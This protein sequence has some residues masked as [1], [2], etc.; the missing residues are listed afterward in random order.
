LE[1]NEP[2]EAQSPEEVAKFTIGV[3]EA[4]SHGSFLTPSIKSFKKRQSLKPK[5]DY[6]GITPEMHL[7][8]ISRPQSQWAIVGGDGKYRFEVVGASRYQE[9]LEQIVGGRTEEGAEHYCGAILIPE[10]ENQYDPNAVVIKISGSTVAYLRRAVAEQFK[11]LLSQ[12]GYLAAGCGA[13]I[14]GG[15]DRGPRDRGHL[16]SSSMPVCLLN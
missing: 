13:V 5:L 9:E 16:G 14:V 11:L 12:R 6:P 10:P 4:R 1:G 15:W 8:T 2:S 7:P 3:K